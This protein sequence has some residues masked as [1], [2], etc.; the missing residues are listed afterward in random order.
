MATKT[1]YLCLIDP[2]GT[3]H[4]GYLA[5]RDH[6]TLDAF[7]ASAMLAFNALEREDQVR[8]IESVPPA[9]IKS[10]W[11]M[12]CHPTIHDLLAQFSFPLLP[13]QRQLS[14]MMKYFLTLPEQVQ[15][16]WFTEA[17][18]FVGDDRAALRQEAGAA[19]VGH[20]ADSH[21]A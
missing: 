15:R 3:L 10:R 5:M 12:R 20:L 14:G 16:Q 6:D 13:K 18:V 4:E 11:Q 7:A 1:K 2:G 19:V 9:S 8:W 21:G 17:Y